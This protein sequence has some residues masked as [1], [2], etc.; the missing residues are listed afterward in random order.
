MYRDKQDLRGRGFG[1]DY[2][3]GLK[4]RLYPLLQTLAEQADGHG[5]VEATGVRSRNPAIIGLDGE[6]IR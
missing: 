6:R 1:F 2:Y 3:P 4:L 5:S